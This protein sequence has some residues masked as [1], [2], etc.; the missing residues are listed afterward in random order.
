MN[1]EQIYDYVIANLCWNG[2]GV[3]YE[4]IAD[5]THVKDLID[6]GKLATAKNHEGVTMLILNDE[7]YF[8]CE[9]DEYGTEMNE[10]LIHYL[11]ANDDE[12]IVPIF[13]ISIKKISDDNPEIKS[14][15][16]RNKTKLDALRKL[17]HDRITNTTN[18]TED[19][20]TNRQNVTKKAP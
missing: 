17:R 5:N 12:E 19:T 2:K 10:V 7:T 11:T 9:V 15:I 6:E 13:D 8:R 1:K 14:W 20:A 18:V 3:Y 16:D 4:P